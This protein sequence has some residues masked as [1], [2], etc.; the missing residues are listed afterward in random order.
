MRTVALLLTILAS[1]QLFGTFSEEEYKKRIHA[2][3]MISDRAAAVEEAKKALGDYPASKPLQMAYIRALCEKG[4]EMEAMEQWIE[5]G[6]Q[7]QEEKENRRILELLAWGVL[8]KGESSAQISIRM[9]SM[10]GAAFTRDAKAIPILLGHLRSSNALLRSIAVKLSASFGDAP[11]KEEIA[12]LLKEEK[13]WYV[14][15]DVIKAAGL[16]RMHELKPDLQEIVGNPRTLI[17]EKAAAIIALVSMYDSIEREELLSL[18]RSNRAGLRQLAAEAIAHLHLAEENDLLLPLLKDASSDV[19]ISAMNALAIMRLQKIGDT[20]IPE[21]VEENLHNTSAEVAITASYVLLLNNEKQG[22]R[23]LAKWL[24]SSN[25]EWRRLASAAVAASGKYGLKLAL[26]EFKETDDP[27]VKV[28]LALGLIGQRI[29]V[30]MACDAIHKVFSREKNTLWMW[31]AGSN[32]LFRSL[33]PSRVKHIEHIPH[34][35][36]VVDQLVKLELLSILSILRYPQAQLA[37]REF[38][39]AGTWGVT[40]AAAA[41]LLQEGDEEDLTAVRELLNDPDEKI[42]VQ[43]AMILAIVGSDPSAVKILQ[44]AYPHVDREM[45][46]HI[47]EALAHIGDPVSIPF[48]LDILKEP[49]QILRVVSASALIQC[50]YH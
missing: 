36:K 40:G 11:L 13:V 26:K 37:V 4:D 45:K 24:N 19:R 21:L 12:R 28:N 16:L 6:I 25:P 5:T 15:I 23:H 20:T 8:N 44:E 47:L 46:V 2:H 14:R 43:A 27:Y 31:D 50:L 9:N 38:L 35:P 30:K 22:S 17:E 29:Q 48:L 10:L 39:Q 49:F 33:A 42:R 7:F 32:P 41:T 1:A 34:Y 18:V 3:L